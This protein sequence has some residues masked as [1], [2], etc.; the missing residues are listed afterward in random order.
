MSAPLPAPLH[1]DPATAEAVTGGA[2]HG[3]R[4]PVVVRGATLDS[5]EVR[6]GCLFACF[7]GERVDGHDYAEVAVG[8]GAVL[9]LARRPV[10]V[11]AP[12]LVVSDVAEALAALAQ[13]MRSQLDD[14]I[15]IGVTGSNGKTTVKELLG[16]A[17]SMAG[18]CITRGNYS[19]HLGVPLTI[20]ATPAQTR[21]AVIEMGTSGVGEIG[22]LAAIAS[23]TIGVLT[24]IGPAHL[25]GLGGLSGVAV[26]KAALLA[27]LPAGAPALLGRHGMDTAALAAG[28]TAERLID[29][30]RTTAANVEV[31]VIDSE[32]IDGDTAGESVVMRAAGIEVGIP[33]AGPHN[34][35]NAWIAWR[36]ACAAGCDPRASCAPWPES[37]RSAGRLESPTR[38]PLPAG[39]QL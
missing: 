20:L 9:I 7:E 4:A 8:A 10:E 39:R 34:L 6:D 22:R 37:A 14:V 32:V 3:P 27:A 29:M 21:I 25:E 28:T 16:S 30:V 12:V 1:L 13:R 26:E 19:N 11:P 15:W 23:P 35:A 36:A 5:R 18:R 24:S 17:C 33:M 31:E 38:P 2:W